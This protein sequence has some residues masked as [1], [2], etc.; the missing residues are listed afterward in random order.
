MLTILKLKISTLISP[1][2]NSSYFIN[3]TQKNLK[4]ISTMH[5]IS[6]QYARI[7]ESF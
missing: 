3:Y 5:E 2:C 1:K 4:Q 7:M 6:K